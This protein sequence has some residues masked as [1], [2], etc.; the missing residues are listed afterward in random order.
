ME[1][2]YNEEKFKQHIRTIVQQAEGD[3]LEERP[4][5][6]DE[7]KELA[8]SMGMAEEDWDE[9]Q[10]K[11][12]VHLSTAEKHLQARNFDD[13]IAAAEM[14]TSI[15]PYLK[16]SNSVL[17]KAYQMLWLEDQNTTALKKAEYYARKEL[18]TDPHDQV[19]INVL[20]A[21]NKDK[22]NSGAE[23][24]SKRKF[25]I[26][27]GIILGVLL[28]GYLSSRVNTSANSSSDL[29]NELIIAQEEVNAKYDLVQTAISQRNSM[30]P[31][32]FAAAEGSHQ[33][34]NQLNGSIEQLKS[35]ALNKTGEARFKIEN[36]IDKKIAEAKKLI[37]SYGNQNTIETLMI[38]IEGAENRIA[39]E[40]KSYNDAVK[41]YN[42]LVKQSK[43]EFPSYETQPY[44]NA[45]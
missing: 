14:A 31:Q 40:K 36:Q 39:F 2:Q 4:L 11:A 24:K 34:L 7:L 33:D 43:G 44:Y 13:A 17:A 32:L 26:I 21:L 28:I 5:T 37:Q 8:I 45:E 30:L 41:A 25:V 35:S 19:A 10:K 9:L 23:S 29:E 16:N 18:L 1:G 42:I 27:G 20:S 6:L 22:K 15:N 12:F 38:Q 3:S